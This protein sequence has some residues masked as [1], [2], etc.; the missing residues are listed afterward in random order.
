MILK[1]VRML[2]IHC[3]KVGNYIVLECQLSNID[4]KQPFASRDL[5]VEMTASNL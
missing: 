3:G 4:T 5:V 1:G 2:F